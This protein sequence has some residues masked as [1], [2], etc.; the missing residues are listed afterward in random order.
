MANSKQPKKPSDTERAID[1]FIQENWRGLLL[2]AIIVFCFW[3]G[4][5]NE[6]VP[7]SK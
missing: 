6:P 2:I 7:Y 1:D 3:A 5:Q 4:I